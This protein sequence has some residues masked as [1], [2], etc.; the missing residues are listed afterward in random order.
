[1]VIFVSKDDKQFAIDKEILRRERCAVVRR[2]LTCS[3]VFRDMFSFDNGST[4]DLNPIYLDAN[5]DDLEALFDMISFPP[6]HAWSLSRH[7]IPI[8]RCVSLLNTVS[9]YLFSRV[10]QRIGMALKEHLQKDAARVLKVSSHLQDVPLARLALRQMSVQSAD[11]RWS[12]DNGCE[13]HPCVCK[14]QWQDFDGLC[15][16][17]RAGLALA[18]FEAWSPTRQSDHHHMPVA[19]G[20][21]PISCTQMRKAAAIF[22]PE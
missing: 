9:T 7:P 19:E 6:G 16:H 1:M 18:L 20:P 5:A 17:W 8:G 12:N 22:N 15:R 4:E 21:R 14:I 11:P 13:K 3:E 10:E 2:L